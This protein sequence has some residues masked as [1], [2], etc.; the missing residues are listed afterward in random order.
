MA[1]IRFAENSYLDVEA[2]QFITGEYSSKKEDSWKTNLV[3]GGVPFTIE[4]HPGKN[5][6]DAYE[7]QYKHA[8]TEMIPGE[9][10]KK[11]LFA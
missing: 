6:M 1:V 9:K 2:I 3:I 4:G 7:W 11:K 10:Y 5:I 8:I